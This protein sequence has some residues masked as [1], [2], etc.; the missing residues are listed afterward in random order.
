MDEGDNMQGFGSKS[1]SGRRCALM[2]GGMALVMWVL[3]GG[4]F[5]GNLRLSEAKDIANDGMPSRAPSMAAE[6]VPE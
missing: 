5:A 3:C 2:I 1:Q 6:T 4:A